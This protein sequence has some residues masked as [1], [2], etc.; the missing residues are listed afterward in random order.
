M[1]EACMFRRIL[2]AAAVAAA[3]FA[4]AGVASASTV[5]MAQ[6]NNGAFV[7]N[8]TPVVNGEHLTLPQYGGRSVTVVN[9]V[10]RTFYFNG[11]RHYWQ[12]HVTNPGSLSTFSGQVQ[13]AG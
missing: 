2:A 7:E 5:F 11:V 13:F 9:A 10:E 8:T 3:V 1:K 4:G 12:F 6:D